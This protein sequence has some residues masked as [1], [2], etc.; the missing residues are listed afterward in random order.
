MVAVA[1]VHI[2][3]EFTVTVGRALTVTVPLAGSDEHVVA[4]SV[5]VT[6]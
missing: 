3:E 5:I 6:V 2:A 4:G 1:P